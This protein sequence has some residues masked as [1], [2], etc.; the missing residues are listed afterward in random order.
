[1]WRRTDSR[2]EL[3]N[4]PKQAELMHLNMAVTPISVAKPS[5]GPWGA[6]KE[7][8]LLTFETAAL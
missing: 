4:T 1:M 5:A 8:T 3:V 2:S 7:T 6:A